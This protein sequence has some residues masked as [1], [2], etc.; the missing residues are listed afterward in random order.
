[1]TERGNMKAVSRKVAEKHGKKYED[2]K[3]IVA[4][5]GGGISISIHEN[6]RIVDAIRDDAGPFSPERAGSIPLLYVIDM[7]YS[8]KYNKKEMIGKVRG[9][10][11]I[12]AYLGTEDCRQVEQMIAEGNEL[13]KIHLRG[14]GLSDRKRDRRNGAGA[15]RGAGLHHT[16]R[17][18]GAF[19]HDDRHA[20]QTREGPQLWWV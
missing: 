5:L 1:M 19:G 3:L 8:G 12:R 14:R 18:Y 15:G 7:C 4:H 17:R 20:L 16:D 11:G 9:M 6:G 13:A 10:G 2:L